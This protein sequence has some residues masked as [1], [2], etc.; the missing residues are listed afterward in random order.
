MHIVRITL[1]H[2]TCKHLLHGQFASRGLRS[3][4]VHIRAPFRQLDGTHGISQLCLVVFAAPA[5]AVKE[6]HQRSG[7]VGSFRRI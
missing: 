6:Q 3:H 4:D 5:A 7:T 2:H 1:G